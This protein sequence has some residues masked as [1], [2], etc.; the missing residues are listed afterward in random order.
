MY[1]AIA[2]SQKPPSAGT[3]VFQNLLYSGSGQDR[4]R[5]ITV[6]PIDVVHSNRTNSGVPYF[7]DRIRLN[8]VEYIATNSASTSGEQSTGLNELASDYL[9]MNSGPVVNG[10]GNTY[11]LQCFS[12][13][14]GSLIKSTTVVVLNL[15]VVL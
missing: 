12:R 13:R 7:V 2:R 15:V 4:R 3:E 1:W 5:T 11:I 8:G 10:T 9:Q 6:N 14:A